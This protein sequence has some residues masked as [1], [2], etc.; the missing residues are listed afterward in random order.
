MLPKQILSAVAV[1]ANGQV[2]NLWINEADN[3][4]RFCKSL[5]YRICRKIMPNMTLERN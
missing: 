5:V 3:L 2:A 4:V 1:R